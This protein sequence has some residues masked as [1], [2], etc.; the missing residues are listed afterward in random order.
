M[1]SLAFSF[2]VLLEDTH[3]SKALPISPA[4]S[5]H[6]APYTP[7]NPNYL[8]FPEPND[9]ESLLPH[10]FPPYLTTISSAS[11]PTMHRI[12]EVTSRHFFSMHYKTS[13]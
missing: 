13:C 10:S 6:L 1:D 9:L 2:Y 12:N 11:P 8:K 5:P 7:A 3:G 4:S